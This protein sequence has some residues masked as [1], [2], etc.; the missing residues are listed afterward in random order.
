MIGSPSGLGAGSLQEV[1]ELRGRLFH[2]V[3][4]CSKDV[5]A[6]HTGICMA[7]KN[8]ISTFRLRPLRW[9]RRLWGDY[10]EGDRE[11]VLRDTHAKLLPPHTGSDGL[12]NTFSFRPPLKSNV[13]A[14][15]SR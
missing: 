8:V 3:P 10:G 7:G 11:R 9:G 5:A 12:P 1:Y 15:F 6:E 4:S 13:T 14:L 2:L